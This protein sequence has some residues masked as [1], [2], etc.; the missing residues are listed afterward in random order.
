MKNFLFWKKKVFNEYM[1]KKFEMDLDISDVKSENY[2]KMYLYVVI[3]QI[4]AVFIMLWKWWIPNLL[5]VYYIFFISLFK[6]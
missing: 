2:H 3:L 5:G 4:F 1:T 6:K